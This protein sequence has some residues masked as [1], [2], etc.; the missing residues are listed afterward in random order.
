MRWQPWVYIYLLMLLPFILD[1]TEKETPIIL[2]YLQLTISGI[3]FW[4]GLHKF[5]SNFINVVFKSIL[6]D[7]FK[8]DSSYAIQRLS[9]LGY[10]IPL[11]E[12]CIGLTLLVPKTRQMG[13]W[14]AIITHLFILI[15]L[16]PL[17]ISSNSVVYPWNLG[18]VLFVIIL[19]WNIKNKP[20]LLKRSNRINFASLFLLSLIW[21]CPLLNFFNYW[22]NYLSFLL[23]SGKIKSYYIAVEEKMSTRIIKKYNPSFIDLK[24]MT[25]GRIIDLNKWA[26]EDLNVP[27]YAESRV[28]KNISKNFC[29]LK[30]D[31]EKLI[32][33]EFD[34]P[35][36]NGKYDKFTCK[37]L[38]NNK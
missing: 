8:I 16:S 18:M 20:F 28:F 37:D 22:D 21:I 11:V 17:G 35:I 14:L 31:N 12:V 38:L 33:L 29:N 6:I 15:Y 19:F 36:E 23:Y 7:L 13:V 4:S 9:Y 2:N 32:F 24:G 10:A 34:G 3:Y 25:G 5:N 1:Q 27:F 30:I 26:L